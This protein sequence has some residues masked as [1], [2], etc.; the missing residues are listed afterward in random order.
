MDFNAMN[1]ENAMNRGIGA[2]GANNV[3]VRVPECPNGLGCSDPACL[4]NHPHPWNG[5]VNW[6]LCQ[7]CDGGC[8]R[9]IRCYFRHWYEVG[10]QTAYLLTMQPNPDILAKLHDATEKRRENVR[11]WPVHPVQRPAA[12][13][14]RMVAPVHHALRGGRGGNHRAPPVQHLDAPE[15][16]A[17]P[18]APVAM[19]PR[20]G[21][22]GRGGYRGRGGGGRGGHHYQ[23]RWEHAHPPEENPVAAPAADEG[24]DPHEPVQQEVVNWADMVDPPAKDGRQS[25][26]QL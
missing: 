11:A 15:I 12:P 21:R 23:N 13:V 3:F 1:N 22:G 14:Q 18:A 6:L 4:L 9:G 20:G 5:N 2:N 25:S 8:S 24:Q 17:A 10:R 16:Q 7:Y 26:T 19:V